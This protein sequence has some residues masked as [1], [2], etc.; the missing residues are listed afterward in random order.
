M[1]KLTWK[2]V[3]GTATTKAEFGDP[4]TTADYA[5]CIYSGTASSLIGQALVPASASKWR[6]VGTGYSYR[7]PTGTADGIT[8]VT[9]RGSALNKSKAVVKG[10]GAGLLDR[11]LPV[12]A[13]LTVQLINGA[14]GLCWGSSYSAAQILKDAAGQLKAKAP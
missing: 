7:D 13:P 6:S 1:D 4:T 14:N 9:L 3:K 2:W 8:S 12:A 11:P 5:L 10:K